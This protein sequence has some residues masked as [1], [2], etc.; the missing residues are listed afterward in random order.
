VAISFAIARVIFFVRAFN[1]AAF[2]G[3]RHQSC[4]R[5]VDLVFSF[6]Y[7]FPI[8][9]C[10]ENYR[11][12][13]RCSEIEADVPKCNWPLR[14]TDRDLNSFAVTPEIDSNIRAKLRLDHMRNRI[15]IMEFV[16]RMAG[17][18]R[19]DR[20]PR[21]SLSCRSQNRR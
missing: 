12:L 15:S 11:L 20:A 13:R 3:F 14:M 18:A 19:F 8:D 2:A 4:D 6:M 16:G 10:M 7:W 17:P 21:Q 9:F 5:P 1:G